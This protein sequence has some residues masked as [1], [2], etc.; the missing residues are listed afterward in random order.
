MGGNEKKPKSSIGRLAI[1]FVNQPR[2]FLIE[3]VNH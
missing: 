3:E 1:S 2:V